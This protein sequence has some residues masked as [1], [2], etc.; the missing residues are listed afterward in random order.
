VHKAILQ[1]YR[2]ACFYTSRAGFPRANITSGYRCWEDNKKHG[3]SSTNH[4]GK[5]LDM[6][7]PLLPGELKQD[8]VIRSNQGRGILVE[9]GN[10]QIGW[11][12]N[13]RKALEPSE[14]APTWIHMDV[15]CYEP[16]YLAEEYFVASTEALDG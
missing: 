16:K 14:I 2:A 4:M 1:A 7:F 15:R 10:F 12:A 13:N 8:D 9:K 5:A 3:R 11:G 6:D